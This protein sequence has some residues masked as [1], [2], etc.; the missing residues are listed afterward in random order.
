MPSSPPRLLAAL[1]AA[2]SLLSA[3]GSDPESAETSTSADRQET[4]TE[5]GVTVAGPPVV[6]GAVEHA[7]PSVVSVGV[8]TNGE[9]TIGNGTMLDGGAIVTDAF[10]VSQ[11]GGV[12]RTGITVRDGAGREYP[13]VVDGVDRVTRLAVLRARELRSV[14]PA[15]SGEPPVLGTEIATLAWL[16]ARRPS[17]RAGTI[18][19]TG[20]SVRGN[21]IAEVG[22]FETEGALGTTGIGGPVVDGDGRVIGITTRAVPAKVPS[23][24]VAVPMAAASR[25]AKALREE[26]RVRRAFLGVETIEV[27]PARAA[28]L[29]LRTSKGLILRS[30]ATGSPAALAPFK[31]PTGT[32]TI[33]G[34]PI[35]TGGDVIVAVGG[36]PVATSEEL[37]TQLLRR[38][39]GDRLALKVIRGDRS[40]NVPV[41]LGER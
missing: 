30:T 12:A 6:R 4:K 25:I 3:C 8:T 39:P 10:L 2:T 9:T 26:G 17:V 21:G 24:V 41:T 5:G 11:A 37:D 40:V 13:A 38:S 14:R 36:T 33:G 34:K 16:A 1:L 23:A 7:L 31:E 18:V 29:R 20:R 19:S 35:P 32:T 28:E 27:T 15:R 22:L